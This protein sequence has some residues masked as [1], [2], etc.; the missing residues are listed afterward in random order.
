MLA[1]QAEA[2]MLRGDALLCI[3]MIDLAEGRRL[4]AE[5]GQNGEFLSFAA[6]EVSTGNFFERRSR[7][8]ARLN[9]ISKYFG[10]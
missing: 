6:H 5:Y 10:L 3:G 9:V 7:G 8:A 1:N 4:A 2:D